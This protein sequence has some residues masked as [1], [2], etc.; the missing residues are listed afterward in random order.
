MKV[1]LSIIIPTLN[2][3]VNIDNFLSLYVSQT[4]RVNEIII[5]DANSTDKTRLVVLSYMVNNPEIKFYSIDKKGTSVARNY[6]LDK[7]TSSH[8]CFMDADW[9]FL[10]NYFI[11]VIEPLLLDK[12]SHVIV[13]NEKPIT[14]QNIRKYIYLKDKNVSF[15]LIPKGCCPRWNE[16]L[17]F[18]EDRVFFKDIFKIGRTK[19]FFTDSEIP[20][21]RA[22]GD[23]NLEKFYKRYVWYGKTIHDYV[24][25]TNDY[26]MFIGHMIYL[27][28][29]IPPIFLIPFLRGFINGLKNIKYGY[30]VPFGMGLLELVVVF[31]LITS[32]VRN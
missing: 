8:V 4:K 31:G 30:D 13:T 1:N 19:F 2:E 14:Y 27:F 10:N 6:G 29:I 5:V 3:E 7:A 23:M 16:N 21:S 25:E 20:L 22:D 9:K 28:S 15:M 12:T 17:G 24:L 11:E 32:L 26:K 18:G